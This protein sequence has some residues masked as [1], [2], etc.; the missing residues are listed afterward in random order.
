[1]GYLVASVAFEATRNSRLQALS[2]MKAT[3][4]IM[5][6]SLVR[7]QLAPHKSPAR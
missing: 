7:F 6:R 4:L 5:L 3:A 1:M 2:S